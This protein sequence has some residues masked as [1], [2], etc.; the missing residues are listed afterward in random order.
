VDAVDRSRPDQALTRATL[1][2]TAVTGVAA[3]VVGAVVAGGRGALGAALGALLV[4]VFFGVTLG[5]VARAR[6]GQAMLNA[7]L[8]TYVLTVL[9]M[10][11]LIALLKGTTAFDTKVFGFTIVACTVVWTAF[12][13]R[14][15]SRQ[16]ILYV[17]PEQADRR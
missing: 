15:F 16:R 5:V 4:L 17:D 6:S 2:P 11:G 7:A 9:V 3:V 10:L 14:A 12:A 1:L 8:L 13:V